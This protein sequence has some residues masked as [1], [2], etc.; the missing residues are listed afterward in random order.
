MINFDTRPGPI[1]AVCVLWSLYIVYGLYNFA[2]T[3][4]AN[5]PEWFLF[6]YVGL[7]AFYLVAVVGLWQMRK[8]GSLLFA[9]VVVTEQG[10]LIS[11]VGFHP[12]SL[13]LPLL[14]IM[15]A[16]SHFQEMR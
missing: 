16:G 14:V 1:S 3:P 2:N 6:Y 9:A 12:G 11:S 8:W 15:V 10:M 7:S 5:M 13:L 4:A